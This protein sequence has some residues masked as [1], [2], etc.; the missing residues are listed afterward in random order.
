MNRVMEEL[1]Q[2]L[3]KQ[4]E[5]ARSGDREGRDRDARQAARL[6]KE[7]RAVESQLNTEKALHTIT[8]NALQNLEEDCT[9]LRQQ[10]HSIRRRGY[11]QDK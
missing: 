9:R 7:L 8:K 2:R 5:E 6:K 1:S 4:M 3:Q 11:S 10:L